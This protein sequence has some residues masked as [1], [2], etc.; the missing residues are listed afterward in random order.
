M[1][2]IQVDLMLSVFPTT[3][4]VILDLKLSLIEE[5]LRKYNH[6]RDSGGSVSITV[7]VIRL[8]PSKF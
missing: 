5:K 3:E 1:G 6:R 8:I 2:T 4:D 7:C